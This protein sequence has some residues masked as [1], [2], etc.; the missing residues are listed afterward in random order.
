MKNKILVASACVA[1]A[2]LGTSTGWAYSCATDFTLSYVCI[3]DG[4]GSASWVAINLEESNETNGQITVSS[5]ANTCDA[6]SAVKLWNGWSGSPF[7]SSS[8]VLYTPPVASV[9]A[10]NTQ[11]VASGRGI[12]FVKLSNSTE[13]VAA[14]NIPGRLLS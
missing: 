9:A 12:C 2:V 11:A 6:S 8:S 4:S 3:G 1:L 5:T 10:H 13:Y 7:G 14:Y